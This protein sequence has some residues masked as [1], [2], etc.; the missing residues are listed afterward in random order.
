MQL[1]Q[2]KPF[3]FSRSPTDHVQL[4][5]NNELDLQYCG[6]SCGL[7]VPW[8]VEITGLIDENEPE[9]AGTEELIELIAKSMDDTYGHGGFNQYPFSGDV[10]LSGVYRADNDE[11]PPLDPLVHA[12]YENVHMYVYPYAITALVDTNNGN[13]K[14]ARFD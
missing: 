13:Q 4:R 10:M 6:E 2:F 14:I 5:Y 8:F 12:I 11:D 1:S 7:I 9:L 3:N